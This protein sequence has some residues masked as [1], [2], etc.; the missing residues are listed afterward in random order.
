VLEALPF[1]KDPIYSFVDKIAYSKIDI[2]GTGYSTK[3]SRAEKGI[4][5][6]KQSV[7]SNFLAI[8]LD[9]NAFRIVQLFHSLFNDTSLVSVIAS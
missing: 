3:Q 7:L 6:I 9:C 5:N 8:Y 4:Q 1:T 2:A